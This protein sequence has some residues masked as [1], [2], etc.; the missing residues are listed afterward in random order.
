MDI[1]RLIKPKYLTVLSQVTDIPKRISN[2]ARE[3]SK[4]Y[5]WTYNVIKDLERAGLVSRTPSGYMAT[6]EL[7]VITLVKSP[8]LLRSKHA[9]NL[10]LLLNMVPLGVRQCSR[11]LGTSPSEIYHVLKILEDGRMVVRENGKYRISLHFAYATP[12]DQNKINAF[13]A[14][15]VNRDYVFSMVRSQT[16]NFLITLDPKIIFQPGVVDPVLY[17]AGNSMPGAILISHFD[18]LVYLCGV[19]TKNP[20]FA[21]FMFGI[22]VYGEPWLNNEK[23]AS[24]FVSELEERE[25]KTRV[26]KGL[27]EKTDGEYIITEKGIKTIVKKASGNYDFIDAGRVRIA[28]LLP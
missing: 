15:N 25:I 19:Y 4:P 28:R 14:Q 24:L 17:A 10:L 2:I 7:D 27:L 16:G 3:I 8:H 26:A 13:F 9:G 5:A 11:L 22:P 20:V 1:T 18:W 6:G 23:L 21:E 12:E